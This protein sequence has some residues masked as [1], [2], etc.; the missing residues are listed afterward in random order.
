MK[1]ELP[2][3]QNVKIELDEEKQRI[4]TL[5]YLEKTF[6]WDRDWYISDGVVKSSDVCYSSHTFT[7]EKV[8][9]DATGSDHF[10]VQLFNNLN[11]DI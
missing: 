7:T 2:Y 4:I 3:T 6:D 9:R 10:A 5:L 11:T 8:I 1:I